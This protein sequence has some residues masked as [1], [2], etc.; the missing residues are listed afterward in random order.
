MIKSAK[1]RNHPSSYDS[2][3]FCDLIPDRSIYYHRLNVIALDVETHHRRPSVVNNGT[4]EFFTMRVTRP[5]D[6]GLL[7]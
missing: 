3:R 4:R 5:I 2:H 6:A 7:H 1:E